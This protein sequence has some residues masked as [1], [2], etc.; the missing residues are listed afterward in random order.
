MISMDRISIFFRTDGNP[1]LV[2]FL[3][4]RLLRPCFYTFFFLLRFLSLWYKWTGSP[5]VSESNGN[6]PLVF[7]FFFVV[8]VPRHYTFFFYSGS[9]LF[10]FNGAG[11]P[12]VSE[13]DGIP[14]LVVLFVL[15]SSR[16]SFTQVPLFMMSTAR[17]FFTIFPIR[18]CPALV[19]FV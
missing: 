14:P 8:F 13:S 19:F 9:S 18:R 15:A 3:F 4:R 12:S 2:F 6:P 11:S 1:P 10:D 16:S 17:I 7:F 5:S